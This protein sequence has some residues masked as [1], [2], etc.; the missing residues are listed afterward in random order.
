MKKKVL[1]FTYTNVNMDS[2]INHQIVWLKDEYELYTVCQVP[3]ERY[4]I[5]YHRYQD[6]PFHKRVLRYPLL[7]LKQYESFIWSKP[8]RQ[9]ASALS[10]VKYDLIIVHHLR[11]LP[12]A[13]EIAQGA[14]VILYA[15]EYYT[16]VYD[17]SLLWRFVMKDYYN[18]LAENYLTK[19]DMAITV[20]ESLQNFYAEN[21]RIPA[22]F[23]HNAVDYAPIAPSPT[24]FDNIRMIHHGL[25]GTSRKLELMIDMVQY[26]DERFSLTLILVE[27]ST[28]SRM[29]LNKLKKKAKDDPRVYFLDPLPFSEI[30]PFSNSFDIG[31]FFMPPTNL[32]EEYSLA[33]KLFQYIQ[34]RL[35]LAISPLPEMKKLVETYDLGVCSDDYEPASLARK[36]NNL[37][38][39]EIDYYKSQSHKHAKELGAETNR[40]KFIELIHRVLN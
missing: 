1:I 33:H 27:H 3:D 38:R 20:N 9:I 18:W 36:L 29:Y 19:C 5:N 13:F 32:N 8:N 7:K 24:D 22:A 6:D 39:E 35:V 23:I 21:F 31:L 4:D 26:L 11:L 30:I 37:T 40:D 14:K 34:A 12:I 16:E 15:H 10:K 17:D 28:I 2:I 25:A